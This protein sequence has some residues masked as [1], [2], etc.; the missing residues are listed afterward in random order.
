MRSGQPLQIISNYI[1]GQSTG[2]QLCKY[3]P[4]QSWN[5]QPTLHFAIDSSSSWFWFCT[6][7]IHKIR[8]KIQLSGSN[9]G[10]RANAWWLTYSNAIV[11]NSLNWWSN[12]KAHVSTVQQEIFASSNYNQQ[13][14][15]SLDQGNSE[16]RISCY[17]L[18]K[19][20]KF[21]IL[22]TE[23]KHSQRSQ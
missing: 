17:Q 7:C 16:P 2:S 22:A 20:Q 3:L 9:P 21:C 19:Q 8:N 4:G 23:F 18:P 10:R 13:L 5:R 15:N 11:C 14:I 12:C 6:C 1:N